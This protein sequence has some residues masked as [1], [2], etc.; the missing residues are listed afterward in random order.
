MSNRIKSLITLA[1]I[2]LPIL[3]VGNF[4]EQLVTT[5]LLLYSQSNNNKQDVL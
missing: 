1:F 4:L 2:S 3:I 5:N